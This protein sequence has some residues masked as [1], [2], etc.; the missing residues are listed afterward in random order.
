MSGEYGSI[1]KRMHHDLLL[2]QEGMALVKDIYLATSGF[3]KEEIYALTS[4]M[5][6][7]AISIPSNIAEGAARRGDKEFLQF[8]SIARGSVCEL[9]TQVI[10][11][12]E[13]GF[14]S[15]DKELLNKTNKVFA[16]LAG[17]MNSLNKRRVAE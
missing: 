5:R 13:L 8:L 14:L 2:W 12:K 11:A 7:A 17:L 9:E 10:L 1:P 6:R 16:L 4:Q 15:E 3:P